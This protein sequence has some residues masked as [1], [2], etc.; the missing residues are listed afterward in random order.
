[1]IQNAERV[2]FTLLWSLW[3]LLATVTVLFVAWQFLA[4]VNFLYPLWYDWLDIEQTITQYGPQNR[5][6]DA[7]EGTTRAERIRLFAAIV[8]GIHRQDTAWD[9]LL[10]HNPAGQPIATLLT[11]PEIIHL[12][13]VAR[14]VS[15]WVAIGW[16]AT[17]AWAVLTAVILARRLAMPSIISLL[18]GMTVTVTVS[19]ILILLVGPVRVFY[20]LHAWIFPPDHPWFFYYQDSL[21]TMLMKA[22]D[23]FAGIVASWVGFALLLLVGILLITQHCLQKLNKA[24]P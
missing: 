8:D 23:I 19:T 4:S 12:Q 1:M 18:I 21:M 11:Q 22:P 2:S 16:T 24:Q 6:R 7:F 14:L 5:Y 9:T 10:Y 15:I 17:L 20:G 13:D 3:L